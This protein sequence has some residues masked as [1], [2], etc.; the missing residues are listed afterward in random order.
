M[1]SALSAAGCGAFA[2]ALLGAIAPLQAQKT[3]VVV[4]TNGNRITGE[5]K[6]LSHGTL[7]YSTDDMGDLS[8]EWTKVVRLSSNQTF[9]VTLKS[10]QK[11]FGTLVEGGQDGTLAISG[12]ALN[13]VPVGEVVGIAPVNQK[14]WHRFSGSVDLG[15]TYAKVNGN[16]QLSSA[17]GVRYRGPS[18]IPN[19]SSAPICRTRPARTR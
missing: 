7:D 2:L 16:V 18:S 4:M 13:T 11:F 3:D 19:S 5:V 8:I 12:A 17:G 1:A 15:F 6:D 14:F 10:G 9:E